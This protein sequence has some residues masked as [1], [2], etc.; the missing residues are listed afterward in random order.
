MAGT[1][2]KAAGKAIVVDGELHRLLKTAA[3]RKSKTVREFIQPRLWAMVRTEQNHEE[4][5]S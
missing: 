5:E 4:V 2:M 1:K 3:A